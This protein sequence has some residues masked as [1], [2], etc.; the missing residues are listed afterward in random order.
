[1]APGNLG[2]GGGRD[3]ER[4]IYSFIE[5]CIFEREKHDF[6]VFSLSPSLLKLLLEAKSFFARS[7]LSSVFN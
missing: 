6:I 3:S 5:A 4:N 7:S 1:M 2:G